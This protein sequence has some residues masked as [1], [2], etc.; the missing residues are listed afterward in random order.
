MVN[1]LGS[2]TNEAVEVFETLL[3][4]ETEADIR[5]EEDNES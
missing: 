4:E 2:P 5:S 3:S 1:Q